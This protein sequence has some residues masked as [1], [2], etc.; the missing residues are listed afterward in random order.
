MTGAA[1]WI[2][3][4][5]PA[6]LTAGERPVYW[7]RREFLIDER[8]AQRAILW[9]SARGL[10]EIY[11]NGQ[12]VGDAE[13]LPG[14]TQ[15]HARIQYVEFDVST[16]LQIGQ[17]AI[18][19][20]LADGWFRGKVGMPHATNQWG[21]YTSA[22]VQ[23]DWWIDD[24]THKKL[25][26][27]DEHWR[28][29]PSHILSAD[30]IDG[31]SEDRRLWQP[32][33]LQTGF[34]DGAWA[35]VQTQPA[36]TAQ[37]VP[38]IAPPVRRIQTLRPRSVTQPRKGVFVFD[39]GQN[40]NGWVRLSNLGLRNTRLTL[41]HGEWLDAT[42]DVTTDHLVPN[43]PILPAPLPAGQIDTVIS[44]GV[45]N[46]VFEPHFTTHG[47]QYVRVEGHPG[48][49]SQNDLL[50]V[51]VH[52]DLRRTGWFKCSDDQ[53]NRLHEAAVWSLRGNMCDVP[54][55]CPQR[56][57][58]GWTG[59]W[60]LFSP[61]AAFLY[62]ISTFT[63][64]WLADVMLDQRAD[65]AIANISPATD[66]EGFNGP[67]GRLH[68]S[69]G[70]GDV[71]VMSPW[72][73]YQA[74]GDRAVLAETW[75]A[76]T[77]W[78]AFGLNRAASGRSDARQR[79]NTHPLPHEQY[80]W[81]TG[82]HWGEW[83]EPNVDIGDFRAFA[84]RDKSD[85]A[86]AY[87]QRSVA[88]LAKIAQILEKPA[89]VIAHYEHLADAIKAAWQLEFI[90]PDGN[91]TVQTQGCHVRALAFDLVPPEFRSIVAAALVK[92]IRQA[93]NKL[94]T[95]FLSTPYL[96]PVL[97]DTGHLEVAYELLMQ[98]EAPSWFY[99]IERGATTVWERWEGVDAHGVPHESL[100]HYSKGAVISFLHHYVA[101]LKATAP[102]YQRFALQ[103]R[104]GGGL[105]AA[106][107][108]FDTPHGMIEV[109]WRIEDVFFC[110]DLCVPSGVSGVV[111]LPNGAA[112][113][114]GEGSY[115]WKVRL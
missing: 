102:G 38:T 20:L 113:E 32:T 97:A 3:A 95:G 5:E 41:T 83:L 57:R 75:D 46:D 49:L 114:V 24:N 29:A 64:K 84:G 25:I 54:T 79:A 106:D 58:A 14:L 73:L 109:V 98:T 112:S 30:L 16:L 81:D 53:I 67:L 35:Q 72:A 27:S 86:T 56:E 101:G 93:G 13:L 74:Y 17:N 78:V 96:L 80:L 92:L 77:R 51:V 71:I 104:I 110:L 12:R 47:F 10:I 7:L 19:V 82:F 69:A 90:T 23:I 87:L 55:D 36:P 8:P 34:D 39:L 52:S 44:A 89:D 28:Y 91:L 94:G 59:D 11:I 50:G 42:G 4:F 60:Q 107:L 63:R 18:A 88:H 22:S 105:T 111:V 9:A 68:G 61:T 48:E 100:N 65:G 66:F 43:F 15:Y 99:M 62:D 31:Q 6:E 2:G 45:P 21:K 115:R 103:P 26:A 40:I 85:V 37:L 108:K 33:I 1:Q 76:M 70:W